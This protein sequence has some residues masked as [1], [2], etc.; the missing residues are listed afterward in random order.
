MLKQSLYLLSTLDGAEIYTHN[1]LL[2]R[3]WRGTISTWKL[4]VIIHQ[5]ILKHTPRH[6]QTQ[7]DINSSGMD[8]TCQSTGEID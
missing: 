2:A 1:V 7:Q 5:T 4:I 3:E 8:F 6:G